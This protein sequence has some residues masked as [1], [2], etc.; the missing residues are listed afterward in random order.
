[1]YN[2]SLWRIIE[3][4]KLFNLT[5]PIVV[6]TPMAFRSGDAV[7]IWNSISTF[8]ESTYCIWW[9]YI[10]IL[11]AFIKGITVLVPYARKSRLIAASTLKDEEVDAINE[12]KIP[13]ISVMFNWTARNSPPERPWFIKSYKAF[14]TRRKHEKNCTIWTLP[15]HSRLFTYAS[16]RRILDDDDNEAR[17]DKED[18]LLTRSLRT[19][20]THGSAARTA[21]YYRPRVSIL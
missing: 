20:K 4:T 3:E 2:R 19:F 16:Y 12:K 8:V 13:A 7:Y 11:S 1:M 18:G 6:D 21:R 5:R 15:S 10:Y 14:R 17:P 9:R